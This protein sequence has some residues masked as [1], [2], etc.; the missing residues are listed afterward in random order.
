MARKKM[1]V[2]KYRY[3]RR[4]VT[5]PTGKRKSLYGKTMEELEGKVAAFK[6][7][8]AG[9]KAVPTVAEYADVQLAL[10][11]SAVS[12]ATYAGYEEKIR[13]YIKGNRNVEA[14]DNSK[15]ET[16]LGDMKLDEVTEDDIRRT[17]QKASHLSQSSYGTVHMLLR[18]IFSAAKR[19]HLIN[20][21]PTEAIKSVGGKQPKER[22]A[23]TDEQ[24]ATLLEAVRGTSVETFIRIGLFAGLRREEILG[25]RWD[26]VHLDESAPYIE[27]R[28]AWRI[29][30]NQP[31]VT[32]QL[33]SPAARRDVTIPSH[34]AA[35]L[36]AVRDVSKSDYVVS[37]SQGN[38]LSGTQWRNLWRKVTVRSAR[39]RTYK[40]YVN[41]TKELHHI[42]AKL[43]NRAAHN[44]DVTYSI[45]FAVTPHQLRHTYI[46]NLIGAGMDPKTVQYLAGHERSNVTMDIYAKA[47]YH[48][49][50]DLAATIDTALSQPEKELE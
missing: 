4:Q 42:D 40:R 2:G 18:T 35:H 41:G 19:N 14:E 7:S 5:L 28:R 15:R 29:E 49:P 25:L 23:L 22:P 34:L 27:V 43:G 44:P 11:K 12:P 8:T 1:S 45:N 21:D 16:P 32:T 47:K 31:K 17:L 48:R 26:C 36:R 3:H 24:V 13:L 39:P 38:P 33:K 20:D 6:E 30:H 9:K 50:A 10:K 37:D 46:T